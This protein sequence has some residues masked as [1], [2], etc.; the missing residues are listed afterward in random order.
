LE[1]ATRLALATIGRVASMSGLAGKEHV[2][3]VEGQ[4]AASLQDT[5]NGV[6]IRHEEPEQILGHEPA[7]QP[8]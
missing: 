8:S 3:P 2:Q 6:R 7:M 1:Q 4:D 5:L